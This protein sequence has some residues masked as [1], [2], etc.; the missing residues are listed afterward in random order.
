MSII[1]TFPHGR[2][3]TSGDNEIKHASN[4]A[5]PG[6]YR[7]S[8]PEGLVESN[9]G[10]TSFNS[11][12]TTGIMDE[13]ASVGARLLGDGSAAV[14]V[15]I[16]DRRG[17]PVREVLLVSKYGLVGSAAPQVARITHEGGRFQTI[18]QG[19]GNIVTYRRHGDGS[20]GAPVWASGFTEP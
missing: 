20:L 14:F 9:L 11:E 6:K 10:A 15:A 2:L 7:F 19:D 1:A 5:D 3:E 13:R 12:R 4:I 8:V 18:F 16:T 17:D